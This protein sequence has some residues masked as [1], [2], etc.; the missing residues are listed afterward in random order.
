[1]IKHV[2]LAL[3][4]AVVLTGCGGGGGCSSGLGAVAGSV[5]LCNDT[6][7]K[8]PL[9]DAGPNQNVAVGA[10]VTLDGSLSRDP[11]G[12]TLSYSWAW[13]SKPAN[14]EAALASGNAVKAAFVADVAGTY[15][16][17]LVV[18]DGKASSTAATVTVNASRLNSVPVA[19]A[20]T[21][22]VV[23]LGQLVILDGTASS[24]ADRQ[25]ITF[26]WR[27]L[28][29]PSGSTAVLTGD[30][31]ARPTFTPDVVG[32]YAVSL[33]VSDGSSDSDVAVVTITV[34]AANVAPVAHAGLP[35][36]V[37][38][39]SRV[40]LDGS[41]SSDANRDPLT[42]QWTL[43]SKPATSTASLSSAT[44]VRPFF[45]A[46]L[47]G[48]Y[49]FSLQVSDGS[50]SSNF[51]AVT[52]VA[53]TVNAKPVANAGA[54]QSVVVG[55]RVTLD[56]SG[57]SDANRDPLTYKWAIVTKPA[58]STA[59]LSDVAA[60]KP[61]ITPD[62]AGTYVFSLVVNDGIIDSD[63]VN[64][65]VEA[66]VANAAPVANAGPDR[67]VVVNT[68][69]V[70][71]GTASTDANR[72]TL[73]Y[74]WQMVAKPASSTT[75]T[76]TNATQ[77]LAG[78]TPDVLGTYVFSL[79]VRD[80]SLSSAPDV[81]V[82]T[83][84]AANVKPVARATTAASLPVA[85]G[86]TVT[87]SGATSSDG[88]NDPLSYRWTLSKPA[89]STATLTGATTVSPTFVADVAGTYVATLIVNDGQMDSDPAT[90]V[91]TAGP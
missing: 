66:A 6:V 76:L 18:S 48:A 4:L 77:A 72:D 75:A 7:N 36:S 1:M 56:G 87:L 43:V 70:L 42:Y 82:I 9:A 8:A 80:A 63:V 24:D 71:D 35:Q 5:G 38:A 69:V 44:D 61:V 90:L 20:G 65:V 16:I 54:A 29:R 60:V 50:L 27:L 89:G 2:G 12:G 74:Q 30:T 88:N 45:T 22:Q 67:N 79:V 91:I 81:L 46:D 39:G 73:S 49:V 15:V 64:V 34:G 41:A 11:E 28:S 40:T 37:V 83:A 31:T 23:V 58:T 14:S 78:F 51:A 85:P 55:T 32:V 86:T 10:V 84:V 26:R 3:M 21:N 68:A 13:I 19:S 59:S 53:T 52:V 57:S 33:V 17:S 25:P 47:G 62:L